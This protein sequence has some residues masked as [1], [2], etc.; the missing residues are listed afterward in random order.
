MKD[1]KERAA[2]AIIK[3]KMCGGDMELSDD[4]TLGTCNYCGTTM[5]LPKLDDEQRAARFNRGNHFRRTG[6]FD[7]AL[8]VY[9]QI[10][11]EDDTDAEAH[12]CCVLCRFGIEYVEDPATM[13]Y[14][15]TCHRASFDSVQ[16][17]VDYLAAVEYSEGVTKRQYQK[18]A[19]K[20]AEVQKGILAASQNEEP[21]DVFLCYKETDDTTKERTRDSLDAQDIYYKLTEEGYRVFFSRITLEDKAGT[22]YEPYIFAALNSA[23]VMIALG[24]KPEYFSAVWVK[25]EWSRFLALMKKDRSKLLLPCYKNMDP[26]DLPEQL[27]VLQ[28]YDMTKIGFMQDLIRGI[29]KVLK[30]DEPQSGKD[31]VAMHRVAGGSNV[32]AQL[33]RGAL[34]LEDGEWEKADGFFEEVLNQDAENAEAYLGK[35]MAEMKAHKLEDLKNCEQSFEGNKNYR[36]TIRFAEPALADTLN[37]YLICINERN[38]EAAYQAAVRILQNASTEAACRDAAKVFENLADYKDA[39]ALAKQ[40][41]EK[42]MN[43]ANRLGRIRKKLCDPACNVSLSAGWDFAVGLKSDGTAVATGKND[44][45]QCRVSDWT[46]IAAVSAGHSYTVGLKADGTVVSTNKLYEAAEW[47]NIIAVSAVGSNIFGIKTDGTVVENSA[48][49][50]ATAWKDIVAVS[51]GIHIVGLKSDGTVVTL[52]SNPK[53]E[54]NVSDWTDIVAVSTGH[55]FTVGLKSNGT[56]VSVGNNDFGQ[57]NVS[58]WTDIVAVSAGNLHTVGLKSDGTVFAVGIN[59]DGACNVSAW[60][61]IISVCAGNGFT[62]GLKSDGTVVATSSNEFGVYNA[63]EWRLFENEEDLDR[64]IEKRRAELKKLKENVVRERADSFKMK[65][66]GCQI[67]IEK[68]KGKITRIE[69]NLKVSDEKTQALQQELAELKGIFSGKR[70]KEI[71]LE[72]SELNQNRRINT[73]ELSKLNK[74]IQTAVEEETAANA[75]AEKLLADLANLNAE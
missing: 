51:G 2:M 17:D 38:T 66:A 29:H 40:C 14:L 19:V 31:T 50:R 44:K 75:E 57:C 65:A 15:P 60:K 16:E 58:D 11:Q 3:C 69:T 55:Q 74:Q 71:E 34:A 59:S 6:E 5:T 49:D 56:V 67:E 8:A 61:D 35:L 1:Q 32:T 20:I 33:K 53:G 68:L 21:F 42:A 62:M 36:K 39:A 23:K 41:F 12:W 52:G 25:N 72:L 9:E 4:K 54:C 26:Y 13:E 27:S 64:C 18:E 70:R 22:E 24:S 7:K 47:K 46:D 48:L 37:G 28:S 10:V 63:S 73:A 45:G 30:T 43:A